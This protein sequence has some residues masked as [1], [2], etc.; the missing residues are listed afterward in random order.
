MTS[1]PQAMEV[2]HL[3]HTELKYRMLLSFTL[4]HPEMH[5]HSSQWSLN[6]KEE[7]VKILVE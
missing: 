7:I 2:L 6:E 1:L 4:P 5:Y 3:Q